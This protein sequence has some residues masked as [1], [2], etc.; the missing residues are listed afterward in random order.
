MGAR[1]EGVLVVD[2]REVRVLFTN[3]ALARAETALG[4]TVLEIAN[5]ARDGRIGM[6]DTV[7]LLLA[8]MEAARRDEGAGGKPSS[9][10]DAY[11]VMDACG[12]TEVARVVIE[13][14][15]AV[16]SYDG[17]EKDEHPPL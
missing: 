4:K 10:D 7:R 16:L 9:V 14:L 12:F 11:E 2:G 15:A 6:N 1:G 13:A 3:R 5:E 8:G 17:K